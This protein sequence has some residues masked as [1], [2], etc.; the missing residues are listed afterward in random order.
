VNMRQRIRLVAR[1]E[2]LERVRRRSFVIGAIIAF[3]GSGAC[4]VVP[5]IT[6]ADRAALRVAVAANV[7]RSLPGA[8]ETLGKA[9]GLSVTLDRV[10]P[11]AARAALGQ[12]KV[13]AVITG[14]ARVIVRTDTSSGVVSLA[15]DAVA[16]TR[17][18]TALLRAGIGPREIQALSAAVP[19]MRVDGSKPSASRDR[20]VAIGALIL[21]Y[22][23][24]MIGGSWVANGVVEEKASKLAEMLLPS[25]RPVELLAGKILGVGAVGLCQVG[26]AVAGAAAAASTQHPLHLGGATLEVTV[27][28][29][30][31]LLVGYAFYATAFAAAAALVSRQEEV[32]AVTAPLTILIALC[33]AVTVAS[34]TQPSSALVQ[35]LSLTPPFGPMLMPMRVAA[36]GVPTWE[37]ITSLTVAVSATAGLVRL[38]ATVYGG[39]VLADGRRLSLNDALARF[40]ENY[41]VPAARFEAEGAGVE[42]LPR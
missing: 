41:R 19:V 38:A 27:V 13:D 20:V 42:T 39:A 26:A 36:G 6:R 3:A 31:C 32:A 28:A 40:R 33:F 1:R 5:K 11:L 14:G 21:L 4:I 30:A 22:I 23:A 35:I 17:I 7:P 24:L 9:A 34:L 12:R 2:F 8:I 16:Q 15:Q 10:Q 37:L 29:L 18:Q 25:V